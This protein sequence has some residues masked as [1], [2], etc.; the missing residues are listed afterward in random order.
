MATNGRGR[1]GIALASVAFDAGIISTK[2]YTILVFAAVSTSQ[3][4]GAWLEYFLRKGWPLL[5][6][7]SSNGIDSERASEAP[8]VA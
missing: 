3:F 4:A 2:F 8:R 5:T 7:K 6:P 1:P